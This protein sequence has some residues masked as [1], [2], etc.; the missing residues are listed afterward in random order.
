MLISR[1]FCH[2]LGTD[3]TR[4]NFIH[5][6][7]SIL[8]PRH[9]LWTTAKFKVWYNGSFRVA[10]S[11]SSTCCSRYSTAKLQSFSVPY[12]REDR[13]DIQIKLGIKKCKLIL[14]YMPL[15]EQFVPLT[16]TTNWILRMPDEGK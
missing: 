8:K 2:I 12:H 11:L 3:K 13:S 4:R 14:S 1:N 10:V 6:C 7:Q 15:E 5:Y 9:G 16:E